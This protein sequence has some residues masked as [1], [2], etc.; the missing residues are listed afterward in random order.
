MDMVRHQTVR[1]K[2]EWQAKLLRREQREELLIVRRRVEHLPT[3]NAAGDH[4]IETIRNFS[5][6]S[7]GHWRRIVRAVNTS[8]N[9]PYRRDL[10][11]AGVVA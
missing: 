1:V 9:R 2:K 11:S 4:V 3:I 5:T 6:R 10:A 8:V 7:P